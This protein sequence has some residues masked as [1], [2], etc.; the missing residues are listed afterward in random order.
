MRRILIVSLLLFVSCALMAQVRTGT[1]YGKVMDTGEIPLPGVTVT[2]TGSVTAPVSTVT[3]AEGNFRFLSL[4]AGK[5]YKLTAQIQG[6]NTLIRE[7]I[8]VVVGANVAVNLT[9]EMGKLE[10]EVL[11][12]ARTPVLD[13][14]KTTVGQVS[15]QEVLQELPLARSPYAILHI[16]P[17]VLTNK[18]DVGGSEAGS[19]YPIGTRGMVDQRNDSWSMDGVSI[20]DP[21]AAGTSPG[22]YDYDA[23]EEIIVTTGGAD[24]TSMTGGLS[25][26]MVTKRGSNNPTFGGRFFLT[27]ETFQANNLTPA[28]QA[29]GVGINKILNLKDYGFNSGIPLIRE[30]V[31]LWFS[32]GIND[33]KTVNIYG[34]PDNTLLTNLAAKFN[35]QIVP[36]NRF[37]A[38][39]HLG[40]KVKQGIQSGSE[41]PDGMIQRSIYHWGSPLL[42]IQDEHMFGD[43]LLLSMKIGR[44]YGGFTY[45]PVI[46][47][48]HENMATWDIGNQRWLDSTWNYYTKRPQQSYSLNV[49]YFKDQLL[50]A[51]HQFKFGVEYSD[52]R[53]TDWGDETYNGNIIKR[54]NYDVPTVDAN[55][56]GAPDLYPGISK[57][58]PYRANYSQTRVNAFSVYASDTIT[59]KRFNLILGLRFDQQTPTVMPTNFAAVDKASP[60]WQNDFSPDATTAIDKI[61]PG[62]SI[63]EI[64]AKS[65]DGSAFA[66]RSLSPRLGLTWDINGDG[67]TIAK[68]SAAMY[69]EFM[70]TGQANYWKRGGTTGWMHFW[71]MDNNGNSVADLNELYWNTFN[72]APTYALY[73]A[74]DDSGNF[75]G[76]LDDAAGLMYGDY[77]PRSPQNTTDPYTLVDKNAGAM[78][79]SELMLTLEKQILSD[80]G[81]SLVGTYRKYDH[82]NWELSYYPETGQ[83]ESPDWYQSAGTP[84]GTIPV[85]GDT[86]DAKNNEWYYLKPQYGYTPW[87]FLKPRDGY[88]VDFLGVDIIFNKR[89]SNKWMFNGSM[90]WLHQATH[91]GTAGINNKT[92]LWA[93]EGRPDVGEDPGAQS[94]NPRWMV[95]AMGLYQLPYGMDVSASFTA[96]E[97]RLV[98]ETF[99]IIDYS[100]PN[101][102]SNSAVLYLAKFGTEHLKPFINITFRFQKRVKVSN[103]TITFSADVFNVFNSAVVHNRYAK[104][105]G[106]LALPN[107]AFAVNP[108]DFT[109]KNIL[110]PLAARLGVRFNF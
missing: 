91:F 80:F 30:K 58:E 15:T 69:G 108:T 75:V 35:A 4:S 55:G 1:I 77:D 90:S 105:H 19:Q 94:L 16:A 40:N 25:I 51:S 101:P 43:N 39:I 28:L 37:E 83:L 104:L 68:L 103:G 10:N 44:L 50:G 21:S 102:R 8:I 97:G 67:K 22:Y 70:G 49:D 34:R 18:E 89:L 85:M 33:I 17:G 54:V 63:G 29:E 86:K 81:L 78:R 107:N 64:K 66:W 62:V 13:T 31:W 76:N 9:M 60:V 14:K 3:G 47:Q 52:R 109:A 11:V 36:K 2:L 61:L 41:L 95:K 5:D 7:N 92:N 46:D 96:R 74:F 57:L 56:D 82:F 24:I 20:T 42:K 73:R 12:I 23:F 100:L 26:N 72:V 110:N 59:V 87:R 53:T 27:E 93:L 98:G 88:R 79:T 99:K 38:F 71:W 65:D 45:V 84:P 6:F 48:E 32:Y 106:T